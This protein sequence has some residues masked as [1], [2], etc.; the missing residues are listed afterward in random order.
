MRKCIPGILRGF[1]IGQDSV[2][3]DH[4]DFIDGNGGIGLAVLEQGSGLEKQESL[5]AFLKR[6]ATPVTSPR[7]EKSILLHF[8]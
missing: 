7:R 5:V 3:P 8:K 4:P 6:H 1:G 2:A